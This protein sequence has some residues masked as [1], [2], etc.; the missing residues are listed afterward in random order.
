VTAP[1]IVTW[2]GGAAAAARAASLADACGCPLHEGDTDALRLVVTDDGLELREGASGAGVRPDFA[3]LRGS[4]RDW[5]QSRRQPLGRALGRGTETV[6]DATAGLGRDA[7]LM[8]LM[9]Y[10]VTAVERH[11]VVAA[12]LEDGLARA[13][14]DAT[15]AAAIGDRLR[16]ACADARELLATGAIQPDAV[17]LDP[18]FPPKRR[19]SALAPKAIR[20]VRAVVG[21]DP[22]AGAH[23]DAARERARRVVVK[24]HAS[25]PPLAPGPTF[26]VETALVRYDVYVSA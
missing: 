1:V 12:L 5:R 25:S 26:V 16:V 24:R 9:G 2:E 18:M 20:L 19:A 22:D 17:Y 4:R 6:L 23:F 21:V 11:P 8:T 14:H 7:V 13:R 10:A 3:S 15:F